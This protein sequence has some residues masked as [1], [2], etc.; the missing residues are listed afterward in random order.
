MN[1]IVH[2]TSVHPAKDVRIFHKECITLKHAG[3]S[4]GIIAQNDKD[5]IVEGIEIHAVKKVNSRFKRMTNLLWEIYQKALKLNADLYHFHDPELIP[6]GILLRLHGK[7]VIYDVHEDVPRD[8]LQKSWIPLLMRH[9]VAKIMNLAEFFTAKIVSG[10]VTVTP[11]IYKRFSHGHAVEVRNYP[12]LSDF[13]FSQT[14]QES[15]CYTGLITL[16]RG[17]QE[18]IQVA[19]QTH[20]ELVLAGHLQN[21]SLKEVINASNKVNYVGHV[22]RHGLQT[23][24]RKSIAGIALLHP[25]P[26]FNE[27]LPIKLFEYMAAGIP[28]IASHFSLWRNIVEQNH[29]GFCVDPIDVNQISEKV[30]YLKSNLDVAKEMGENGRKA[31]AQFFNWETEAKKLIYFYEQILSR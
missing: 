12:A 26:T 18:M 11:R 2:L 9:P 25:S 17:L 31:V 16:K 20:T 22:D 13:V 10:I 1:K 19:D 27:A 8:I 23:I 30:N 15:L 6:V 14:T 21:P 4:V 3:Y 29:C 5:E 24:Y 7:K 28:V